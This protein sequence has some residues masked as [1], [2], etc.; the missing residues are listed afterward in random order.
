MIEYYNIFFFIFFSLVLSC[1]ILLLNNLFV[2]E[3]A[4]IEKNSP[5][6][7]GFQPF[8]LNIQEFDVKYF[9]IALLFL[10]FDIEVIFLIP[11]ISVF[12]EVDNYTFFYFI[13]FIAVLFFTLYYEWII[14]AF[15]WE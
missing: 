1:L 9:L 15:D 14:K 13:F 8:S 6:E 11:F 3:Y 12:S 4:D 5:Y 10:I 7:C 2:L